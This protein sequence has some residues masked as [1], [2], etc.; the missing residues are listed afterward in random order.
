MGINSFFQSRRVCQPSR[1]P[2]APEALIER[3][4]RKKISEVTARDPT[5][6]SIPDEQQLRKC[7]EKNEED[8]KGMFAYTDGW[9]VA[10]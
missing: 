5:Q 8:N 6:F 9:T 3:I 2:S 7:F 4:K 10:L 1:R